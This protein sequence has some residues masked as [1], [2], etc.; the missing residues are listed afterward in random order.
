MNEPMSTRIKG[1]EWGFL[2]FL[3]FWLMGKYKKIDNSYKGNISFPFL[4][5]EERKDI[6]ITSIIKFRKKNINNWHCQM[7]ET[8]ESLWMRNESILAYKENDWV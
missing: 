8:E 1:D 2:V 7:R 3:I 4:L 6:T 5:Y